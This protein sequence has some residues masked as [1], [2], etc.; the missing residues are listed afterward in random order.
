MRKVMFKVKSFSKKNTFHDFQTKQNSVASLPPYIYFQLLNYRKLP[1]TK[2]STI[3]HGLPLNLCIHWER[4]HTSKSWD[5]VTPTSR[6]F[7]N[8]CMTF[9][10]FDTVFLVKC[11]FTFIICCSCCLITVVPIFPTFLSPALSTPPP[12]PT[13]SPL[14]GPWVLPLLPL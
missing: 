9:S 8:W 2:E 3:L 7:Y 6:M 1:V 10:S 12:P 11:V 4:F 14:P 5:H 13:F